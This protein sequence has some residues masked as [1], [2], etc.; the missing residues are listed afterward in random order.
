MIRFLYTLILALLSPFLLFGLYKKKK[1]KPSFGNRWVEHFGF[2]PKLT[3]IDPPLWIHAVSVGET[4]AVTPFIKRMKEKYPHQKI[5]LTTT[6]STGAEQA[7]KLEGLVEHRYMPLDFPFAVKRFLNR[8]NPSQLIIVETELWLNTL[9]IVHNANIPITVLNARLSQKSYEQYARY[10][11][12]T[13][14]IVPCISNLLCQF[15]SD[16]NRFA[17]L[18]FSN[19]QLTTTGSI[20]FDI[21]VSNHTLEQGNKLRKSIGNR[22]VWVAASTHK[23]ED[24][25]VLSAHKAVLELQPN[26]L[27]ILVPRHPERFDAVGELIDKFNMH[28]ERHSSQ[29]NDI[30]EAQVYL[31]DTMG[32]LLTLIQAADICFMGGSL[33][34]EKVGGHNVIEPSALRKPTI[35]GPSYYNFDEIVKQL[36]SVNGLVVISTKHELAEE[37]T[38]LINSPSKANALGSSAY[39]V[40]AQSKGAIDRSITP[41]ESLF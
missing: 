21:S 19:D 32:E 1:G 29:S 25:I 5:V 38:N 40:Y 26:A 11:F 34:G 20:K 41:L 9:H 33:L 2:S 22:P 39:S 3:S 4:I 24:E 37:V 10:S 28:Y 13:N 16:M 36:T 17:K 31:G 6:T 35:T 15:D 7:R 30:A 14:R 18:G 27:L 23:G 8:I 12:Y